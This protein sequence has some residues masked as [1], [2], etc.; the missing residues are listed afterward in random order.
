VK[1]LLIEPD[2]WLAESLTTEIRRLDGAAQFALAADIDAALGLIDDFRP[3]VILTDLILGARNALALLGELQSYLDT[4]QIPVVVLTLDAA[5][6]DP[7]DFAGYGVR[8]ILDKATVTPEEIV[9]A[10]RSESGDEHVD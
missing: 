6:L 5:R 9:E 2:A 4:R 7:A 3:T 1:V 8:R 10:C